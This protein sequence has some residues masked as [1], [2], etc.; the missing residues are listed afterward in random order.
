MT[1]Y[2]YYHYFLLRIQPKSS[3]ISFQYSTFTSFKTFF[4]KTFAFQ[5]PIITHNSDSKIHFNFLIQINGFIGKVSYS[6]DN[7]KEHCLLYDEKVTN[8]LFTSAIK[9]IDHTSLE[10]NEFSIIVEYLTTNSYGVYFDQG[11][12][13]FTKRNMNLLF[14]QSTNLSD[15]HLPEKQSSIQLNRSAMILRPKDEEVELLEDKNLFY[16]GFISLY[17]DEMKQYERCNC[18]III[19]LDNEI[20]VNQILSCIKEKLTEN[21]I[22]LLIKKKEYDIVIEEN[23]ESIEIT[24]ITPEYY[25][26]I[27]KEST[28]EQII[29]LHQNENEERIIYFTDKQLLTKELIDLSLQGNHIVYYPTSELNEQN[30]LNYLNLLNCLQIRIIQKP[31]TLSNISDIIERYSWKVPLRHRRP[32]AF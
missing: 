27:Q 21:S 24:K 29:K 18:L 1:V 32:A 22:T 14:K 25:K 23:I 5:L 31:L 16:S 11:K 19:E 12:V 10:N 26:E 6:F 28:I 30:Q 3:I 8:G 7:I 13:P 20:I 17:R 4:P 2:E 9:E 15:E